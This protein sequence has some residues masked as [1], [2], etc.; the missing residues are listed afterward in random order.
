MAYVVASQIT[1]S[2]HVCCSCAGGPRTVLTLQH[3]DF[4]VET[5]GYITDC[6]ANKRGWPSVRGG[7]QWAQVNVL[8]VEKLGPKWIGLLFPS[9]ISVTHESAWSSSTKFG[10]F[11]TSLS[12]QRSQVTVGHHLSI[13][14]H[15]E[16]RAC[17][18]FKSQS[19]YQ[20]AYLLEAE[21]GSSLWR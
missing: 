7:R 9:G 11:K 20:A 14:C 21:T 19:T 1:C 6:F 12:W 13:F 16:D 10:H 17:V 8:S 5:K 18:R 4:E 15:Y 3:D 2:P